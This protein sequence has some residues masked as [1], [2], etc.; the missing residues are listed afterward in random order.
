MSNIEFNFSRFKDRVKEE[1]EI[2]VVTP[3]FLRGGSKNSVELRAASFKGM[4]RFWWRAL[5]GIDNIAEMK[6]KE[7]EI[8][9]STEKKSDLVITIETNS[10]NYISK[11]NFS[12]KS[13]HIL[14]YLAYGIF[15]TRQRKISPYIKPGT[16]F[17]VTINVRKNYYEVIKKLLFVL[18]KYSGIGA[19]ARNGFG[20]LSFTGKIN[21]DIN[22]IKDELKSFLSFS[23]Q[24]KLY[25]FQSKSTWREAL[26]DLGN[27]YK[28][29]KLQLKDRNV[30]N[31]K[32]H[33]ID[34]GSFR[35]A[36][37]YFLHVNKL[38]DGQFQGQILFLP[39]K[40]FFETENYSEN[41][42][43]AYL[44]AC[45]IMNKFFE[46]QAEEVINELP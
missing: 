26:E 14:N 21:V 9:G 13:Y 30:V 18:V 24:S 19:K 11:D 46:E 12:N 29:S 31:D 5:Y 3:M 6:Q 34:G 38:P 42:L 1:F 36:K 40:Y 43:E 39:Y 17:K 33:Y 32:R 2:E 45:N 20:S 41:K 10:D 35:H 16:S 27:K 22:K 8:F 44:D 7:D 4:L 25:K 28:E 15:D 37:P 23:E